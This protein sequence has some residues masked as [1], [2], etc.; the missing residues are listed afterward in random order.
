MAKP[1][2]KKAAIA[3]ASWAAQNGSKKPAKF[4]G[5]AGALAPKHDLRDL[6]PCRQAGWAPNFAPELDPH[7][8]AAQPH[9][10]S[11]PRAYHPPPK[12]ADGYRDLDTL[13]K[14][15]GEC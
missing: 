8:I 6:A 4:L 3:P 7:P 11:I 2:E 15:R 5:T 14:V 1:H 12:P 9:A 13:A 10:Q